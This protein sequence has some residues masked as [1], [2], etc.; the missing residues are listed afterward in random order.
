MALVVA[1]M[2]SFFFADLFECTPVTLSL[3]AAPTDPRVHCVDKLSL[4][5]AGAITDFIMDVII[6]IMPWPQVW[7]LHMP[8]R[9]K[10]AVTAIFF[11][12][13]LTIAASITRLVE[14]VYT[15]R[16]LTKGD[17]DFTYF[18]APTVY[19]T[20]IEASLAI[21]AA[22]LPTLRPI[23]RH[24]SPESVIASIR[25]V[26][27]LQSIRSGGSRHSAAR[28][29]HQPAP[30][31]ASSAEALNIEHPMP[32]LHGHNG[33]TKT[34]IGGAGIDLDSFTGEENKPSKGIVD[35]K[36]WQRSEDAV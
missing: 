6:I 17:L 14:F 26:F 11:L 21:V 35:Q 34:Y 15:G 12:G 3:T 28:S 30:S 5:Y 13:A 24:M 32:V 23:F 33:K 10:A 22:T 31:A 27:S 25:S 7:K 9:T 18:I 19:W 8:F 2:V 4:Y 29:G 20:S 1:W 36:T 16:L